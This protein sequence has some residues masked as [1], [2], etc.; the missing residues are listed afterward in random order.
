LATGFIADAIPESFFEA[1]STSAVPL[2][3]ALLRRPAKET[4][5]E[6]FV[7][8]DVVF[9]LAP[10]TDAF[11]S[12]EAAFFPGEILRLCTAGDLERERVITTRSA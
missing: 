12:G 3:L 11:F 5:L 6:L 9:E 2:V 8:E 1:E 10:V 4:S 7:G